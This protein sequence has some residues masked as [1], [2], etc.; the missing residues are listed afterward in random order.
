MRTRTPSRAA[1]E[2]S[3]L[4]LVPVFLESHW[5]CEVDTIGCTKT[6]TEVHHRKGRSGYLLLH[7]PFFR[8]CCSLCHR[9][10]HANP[11]WSY[12]VGHLIRRNDEDD[13]TGQYP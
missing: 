13:W 8:A 10:V 4:R 9:Y 6:A 7:V 3:Y 1:D 11:T 12:E 5:R 2:R